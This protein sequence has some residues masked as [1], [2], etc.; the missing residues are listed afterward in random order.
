[1]NQRERL[2]RTLTCDNPDRPSYGDYLV[3][4]STQGRWESE[5]LPK[6]L[7]QAGLYD[8]FGFDKIDFWIDGNLITQTGPIPAF[9][10]MILDETGHYIIK[11]AGNGDVVKF[12]KNTPP[13]AMP[14]FL[15]HP[16]TDRKSWDE[17]KM[18]FISQLGERIKQKKTEDW[19]RGY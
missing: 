2:I 4:P 19:E 10:E 7:S 8:Y 12:L 13:P 11:R 9:E 14:Q 6:G 3:F 16:V 5:G 18:P 15:S 17:F 1:M